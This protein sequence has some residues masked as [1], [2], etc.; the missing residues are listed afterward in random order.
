MFRDGDTWRTVTFYGLRRHTLPSEVPVGARD[1]LTAYRQL[2]ADRA[3]TGVPAP[4]TDSRP[5]RWPESLPSYRGQSVIDQ[6]VFCAHGT[7]REGTPETRMR[8][9]AGLVPS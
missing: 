1:V 3:L 6:V 7:L 8:R 4:R 5:E 2:L 9:R